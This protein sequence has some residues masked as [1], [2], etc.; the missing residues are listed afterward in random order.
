MWEFWIHETRT[1][2]LVMPVEPMQS[3]ANRTLDG[4]GTGQHVLAGQQLGRS[5]IKEILVGNRYSLAI[6]WAGTTHCAYDGV[7]LGRRINEATGQVALRTKELPSAILA[8][9]SFFGVNQYDAEDGKF[10]ITGRSFA[11]AASMILQAGMAPSSEWSLPIDALANTSGPFSAE[12]LHEEALKVGDM[13]E[14]IRDE[15]Y[16]VD[17]RPYFSGQQVRH[18]PRIAQAITHGTATEVVAGGPGIVGL[19]SLEVDH[20]WSEQL[21]GVGGFGNGTGEDKLYR[22]APA[23]GSGATVD[24]VMDDFVHFQDLEDT[25]RLQ[26]AAT[27]HYE[28]HKGPVEQTTFSLPM[29]TYAEG[30][31]VADPG[32]VLDLWSYGALSLD[33]G[34]TKKRTVALEMDLSTIVRPE[35]QSVAA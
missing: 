17:L 19:A 22:Y 26:R 9:R 33:D 25:T 24:P 20:D 30:P 7:I 15:G 6:G 13:I 8:R 31:A 11:T 16:E 4:T 3:R 29:W 14:Q 34:L 21:T 35:V 23:T 1:G 32:R 12:W 5:L 10:A 28:A 18:A 27:A 2:D